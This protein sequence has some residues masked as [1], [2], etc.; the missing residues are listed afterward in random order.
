MS[1]QICGESLV[2]LVFSVSPWWVFSGK[3]VQ[4]H[5]RSPGVDG[6]MRVLVNGEG[7]AAQAVDVGLHVRPQF[8]DLFELERGFQGDPADLYCNRG[9]H[10]HI[11]FYFGVIVG[12]HYFTTPVCCSKVSKVVPAWER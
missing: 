2:A 7:L 9:A 5:L 6:F 8:Q 1:A 12:C 10:H 3:W 4:A 11:H